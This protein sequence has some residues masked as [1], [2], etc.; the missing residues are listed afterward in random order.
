MLSLSFIDSLSLSLSEL[1]LEDEQSL[2]S[3][4]VHTMTYKKDWLCCGVRPTGRLCCDQSFETLVQ[5]SHHFPTVRNS[6]EIS[7]KITLA[8]D[9][10]KRGPE[11]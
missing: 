7:R 10:L 8:I 11:R 1:L 9:A 4:D 2:E 6:M 5:L 3:V